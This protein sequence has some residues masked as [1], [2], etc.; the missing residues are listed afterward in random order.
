MDSAGRSSGQGESGQPSAGPDVYRPFASRHAARDGEGVREMV[1]QEHVDG[2]RTRE[3]DL[4]APGEKEAGV[5]EKGLALVPVQGDFPLPGETPKG[6]AVGFLCS[7]HRAARI[8]TR[9]LDAL[10]LAEVLVPFVREA[11]GGEGAGTV[12]TLVGDASTRRYHRVRVPGGVPEVAVVMELPDEPLKSDEASG[13]ALPPELPFLNVQRYLAAGGVAVPRVLRVDLK[14]GL[15]ALEDLGDQTFEAAVS[16]GSDADRLRLYRRAID[17]I[18]ALQTLGARRL[19]PECVAFSRRFDEPLLRWELAHFREWYLEAHREVKLPAADSETLERGFDWL[20]GRLAAAPTVLV[21]RDF[22]SRNLM[23]TGGVLR[24]I[25]FQDALMGTRAYDLV[26]LL[27][28]SYVA[29]PAPVLADLVDYFVTVAGIEDGSAFKRLFVLQT[30]QRKL[31]DAGRFVFIDRVRKNPSF[32][33]WIPTSIGY[34]REALSQVPD[35]LAPLAD[36]LRRHL[37]E[38]A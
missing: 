26:A 15:I 32:L 30:L 10:K 8:I 2:P 6:L 12:Q 9:M 38:L 1:V 11:A 37:P 33:R 36:V 17:Q 34:V 31:K 29:L 25:D 23:L 22:Q 35:E 28:D 3:V 21:H 7:R 4:R 14:R 20:A 27:R 19:D 13:P 24:V 5:G 18:V 16:A